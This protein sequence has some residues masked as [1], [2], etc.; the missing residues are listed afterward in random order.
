MELEEP[1][2]GADLVD[3]AR[4]QF[5]LDTF[6]HHCT[7]NICTVRHTGS[8]IISRRPQPCWSGREGCAPTSTLFAFASWM[9]SFMIEKSL[10]CIRG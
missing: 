7:Q 4:S 9:V 8:M 2:Q 5:V 10:W 1:S 3:E 6:Q